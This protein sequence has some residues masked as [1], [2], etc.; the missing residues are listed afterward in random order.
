MKDSVI[1]QVDESTKGLMEQVQSGISSSIEGSIEGVK[2][3]IKDVADTTS[4]IL[5]KFEDFDTIQKSVD[6]LRSLADES[7][8]FASSVN[9]LQAEVSGILES[10]GKQKENI[11]VLVKGL[12]ELSKNLEIY[13]GEFKESLEEVK[14]NIC[15]IKA[16]NQSIEETQKAVNSMLESLKNQAEKF[17][18]TYD[19]NELNHKEEERK[20]GSALIGLASSIEK[21]QASLTIIINLVTP[22]WKKW[23]TDKK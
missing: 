7:K 20:T 3:E 19:T 6:E 17:I 1:M 10:T 9:P 13:H 15:A 11:D 21:I 22:F 8:R 23:R 4:K 18:K 2:G 14:S 5:R 16:A 12:A